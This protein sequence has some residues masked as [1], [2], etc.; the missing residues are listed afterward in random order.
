M[1]LWCSGR[2]L[3]LPPPCAAP[4]CGLLHRTVQPVAEGVECGDAVGWRG[5]RLVAAVARRFVQ[6]LIDVQCSRSLIVH[7]SHLIRNG[8]ADSSCAKHAVSKSRD[9]NHMIAGGVACALFSCTISCAGWGCLSMFPST[10]THTATPNT[11]SGVE[12][13]C[14]AMYGLDELN[15]RDS[16][17]DSQWVY[18]GVLRPVLVRIC[19]GWRG[20]LAI[21]RGRMLSPY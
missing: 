1:R 16:L 17:Q 11:A 18:T 10:K 19:A 14:R 8:I 4:G 13:S 9:P 5:D 3:G 12:D 21:G 15:R 20:P 6:G 2:R 7:N